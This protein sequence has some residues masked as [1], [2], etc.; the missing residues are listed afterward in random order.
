[1]D[2]T[3]GRE[4]LRRTERLQDLL[5]KK[6]V[7]GAVIVQNADLFYFTGTV[8]QSHLFV[9]A[10]GK[11]VLMVK[12]SFP[13]ARE[14]SALE[15]VLPLENVKD[16]PGMISSYGFTG[17]KSI[18]LELDVL[19]ASLYLKYQKMFTPAEIV[20]ISGLIRSVRMI[21][22]SYELN[23]LKKAASLSHSLFSRVKEFLVEGIAEVDLAGRLEAEYRR[24]GHQGFVRMRGFNQEIYY[25]HLLSGSNMGVPSFLDSPTGGPGLNPSFPQSAGFKK[26]AANEP[27]MVDY[28]AVYGGYMVDQARVFCLGRLPDRFA[29]AYGIA[30]EIQEEIKK[31]ARPGVICEDLYSLAISIASRYGLKDHFM[32]YPHPAPFVGHGVGIEL[33]EFPVLARGFKT[34]LEKGMVLALEPK[35]VFPDG[36]AGIENT[37][38]VGEHGLEALTTFDQEIVCL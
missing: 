20:D 10:Q 12:K 9:P 6:G 1:M 17:I 4:L 22:S 21:K 2:L 18:G 15:E 11:P 29:K 24:E 13:R 25:G 36:G 26:I 16:L 32:G 38:V 7:D 14:E 5:Q 8:Q 23:I 35:F 33:D 34:P 30:V 19:P 27:V 3:P 37:F 28:V 31:K